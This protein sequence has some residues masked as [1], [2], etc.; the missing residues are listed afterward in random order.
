MHAYVNASLNQSLYLHIGQ[1]QTA[2]IDRWSFD[3]CKAIPPGI[4]YHTV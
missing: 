1:I 4:Y 3:G 2:L